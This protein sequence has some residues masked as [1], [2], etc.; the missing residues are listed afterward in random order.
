MQTSWRL[1]EQQRKQTA[2]D[3]ARRRAVEVSEISFPSLAGSAAVA[4]GWGVAPLVP[5]ASAAADRWTSG[6]ASVASYVTPTETTNTTATTKRG[7]G[8]AGA[9]GIHAR[10]SAE[11]RR[12]AAA[13]EQYRPYD[14]DYTD[15]AP[16]PADD[17]WIEVSR[18]KKQ[19][20][21]K[22]RL[23]SAPPPPP[24]DYADFGS[25]EYVENR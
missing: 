12:T 13:A 19:P 9:G 25:G 11:V 3:E 8:A 20:A 17:G 24:S 6:A 22:S 7:G 23:T 1:R 5:T 18:T 16:A 10:I 14:D 4:A 21:T 15:D 2:A